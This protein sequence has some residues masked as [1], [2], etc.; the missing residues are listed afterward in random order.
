MPVSWIKDV[1]YNTKIF[2]EGEEQI[3]VISSILAGYS[4]FPVNFMPLLAS[5]VLSGVL[6]TTYFARLNPLI[7]KPKEDKGWWN[8]MLVGIALS[9]AILPLHWAFGH[10]LGFAIR[11]I[12]LT[13]GITAWSQFQGNAVKEELGRGFLVIFTLPLSLI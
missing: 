10:W 4:I 2:F 13:A 8:W 5:A 7:G 3:F 6:S 12:V 9:L 1:G 11:S